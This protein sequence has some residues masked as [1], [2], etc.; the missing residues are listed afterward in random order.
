[1]YNNEGLRR[2]LIAF[3]PTGV[4]PSRPQNKLQNGKLFRECSFGALGINRIP[5]HLPP[6]RATLITSKATQNQ[7]VDARPDSQ[8]AGFGDVALS[9]IGPATILRHEPVSYTK[10]SR[11]MIT[12]VV[13]IEFGGNPTFCPKFF[14]HALLAGYAKYSHNLQYFCRCDTCIFSAR[15]SQST[16]GGFYNKGDE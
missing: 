6:P 2:G 1:M 9:L 16:G 13:C 5:S 7:R 12:I 4:F 10:L 14:A 11:S 8:C 15:L 3:T